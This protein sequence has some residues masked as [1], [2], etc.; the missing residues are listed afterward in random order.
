MENEKRWH[1]DVIP[2]AAGHVI[3]ALNKINVSSFYLAGGTALA[4]QF[5]HRISRD[6][7][8]FN[9]LNFDVDKI[10]DE[11][12]EINKLSVVSKSKETL[13]LIISGIKVSFL[14]YHYPILFPFEF[15]L[16]MSIADPRDIGCMKI[17]AIAGRGAKRDFVDLYTISKEYG[18][19]YLINL[20]KIKYAEI[21]FNLVHAFKSLTYFKDAENEP[22][23]QMLSPVSWNQVAEYFRQEAPKLMV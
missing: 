1:Q 12:K 5:G 11:L 19:P 4:L 2:E 20:F 6:L 3:K 15:F 9:D 13:H 8:F 17:S 22:M 14:G 23:P 18:L 21:D 16:G 10:I 7:D